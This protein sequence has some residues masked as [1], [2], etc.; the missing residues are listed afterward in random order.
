MNDDVAYYLSY[1][2]KT[3][4]FAPL[5][6]T[7]PS[8]QPSSDAF[9]KVMLAVLER[10]AAVVPPAAP[11]QPTIDPDALADQTALKVL[12]ALDKRAASHAAAEAAKANKVAVARNGMPVNV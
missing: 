1:L 11:G 12:A 5:P 2:D 8:S 4:E 3:G 9:T 10:I 7:V 6:A